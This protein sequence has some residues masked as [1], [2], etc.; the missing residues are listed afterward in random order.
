MSK[1]RNYRSQ[2]LVPI[3]WKAKQKRFRRKSFSLIGKFI[4]KNRN[5]VLQDLKEIV[6]YGVVFS[7]DISQRNRII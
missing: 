4:D 3:D 2:I 7:E 6:S 1:G 5:E